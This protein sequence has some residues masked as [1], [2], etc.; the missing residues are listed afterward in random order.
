M[1]YVQKAPRLGESQETRERATHCAPDAAH[2]NFKSISWI[3]SQLN[4]Q[5]EYRGHR[6][7]YNECNMLPAPDA[8]RS[9]AIAERGQKIPK[10]PD[11]F[12]GCL[13]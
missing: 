11:A 10:S 4:P 2:G 7:G 3:K 1:N 9:I 8:G 5:S 13:R 6:Q 12:I